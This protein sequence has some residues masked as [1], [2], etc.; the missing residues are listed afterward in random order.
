MKP[1]RIGKTTLKA[2]PLAYGCWRIAGGWEARKVTAKA[3]ETGVKA[4]LAAQEAGYTL[5]DLAD[6][7]CEGVSEELMGLAFKQSKA[8]KK[9]AVI[10]TKCGIR[11]PDA[12]GYADTAFGG[13][14]C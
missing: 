14:D 9:S 8:L 3:R 11:V 6:I 5:F 13:N 2:S 4:L 1:T 10:T 12:F 7:Y